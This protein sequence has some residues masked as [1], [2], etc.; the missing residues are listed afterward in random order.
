[1]VVAEKVAERWRWQN[2]PPKKLVFK[3]ENPKKKSGERV[4]ISLFF[5]LPLCHSATSIFML[6]I[7]NS[8]YN[9]YTIHYGNK[10]I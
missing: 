3:N 5:F 10:Y 8:I 7:Y 4:E 2:R 1:M 9:K 6:S